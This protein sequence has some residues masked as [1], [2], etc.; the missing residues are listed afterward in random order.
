MKTFAWS[1]TL[2]SKCR[3]SHPTPQRVQRSE[4]HYSLD[5]HSTPAFGLYATL[6]ALLS[7]T[8]TVQQVLSASKE[9][10]W[11]QMATLKP[12]EILRRKARHN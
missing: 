7:L 11:T 8:T 3:S 2:T 4:P 10:T 5:L 12:R 1:Q 9:L 6:A